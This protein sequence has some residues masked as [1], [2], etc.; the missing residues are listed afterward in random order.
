MGRT[1]AETF[2]DQSA[3]FLLTMPEEIVDWAYSM[4]ET[5]YKNRYGG[6]L[7][8]IAL[9]GQ[10]AKFYLRYKEKLREKKEGQIWDY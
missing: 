6:G 9:L 5:E 10:S 3:N 1:L 8:K 2:K 7:I 4:N